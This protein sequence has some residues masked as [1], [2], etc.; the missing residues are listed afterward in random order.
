MSK[1]GKLKVEI[2]IVSV[3]KPRVSAVFISVKSMLQIWILRVRIRR[4][5][6]M[7]VSMAISVLRVTHIG[8]SFTKI[9]GKRAKQDFPSSGQ[10][11]T[12]LVDRD[13][14][15]VSHLHIYY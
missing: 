13:E 4:C 9:F 1:N 8:L 15:P 6:L 10:R 12:R 11:L 14:V 2:G 3:Q 7:S 5:R